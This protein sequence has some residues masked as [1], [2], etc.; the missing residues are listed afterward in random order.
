MASFCNDSC[1]RAE[2]LKVNF[3]GHRDEYVTCGS[4]DGNFFVW[5]KATGKI[6]NVLEGDGSV[7]NVVE[8]NPLLQCIAVSGIDTSVKVSRWHQGSPLADMNRRRYLEGYEER[9]S[10]AG[11]DPWIRYWMRTL[12]DLAI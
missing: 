11:P 12:G 10:S 7:V 4:D 3:L 8:Q 6:L 5:D 1:S 2:R 9:A